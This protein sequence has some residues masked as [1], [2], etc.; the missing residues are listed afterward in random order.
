[1]LNFRSILECVQQGSLSIEEGIDALKRL[2]TEDLGFAQ[3]DHHRALRKGFPEVVYCEGKTPEQAAQILIR[4]SQSGEGPVLG[5]RADPRVYELVKQVVPEMAYHPLSRMLVFQGESLPAIGNVLV[6]CAGTSDIPVAEEAALT[7]R[8]MGARATCVYDVGVAGIHRL[9]AH[10]EEIQRAR[11][12]VVV[13][14]M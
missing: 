14:G 1:M 7:A 4:L 3:I 12:L 8:A 11:V 9:F 6:L 2:H 5:T 13:A 10:M